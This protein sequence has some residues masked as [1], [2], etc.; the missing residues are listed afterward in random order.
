VI[1]KD[2]LARLD[3]IAQAMI[4]SRPDLDPLSLHEWVEQH[5][6]KLTKA[7]REAAYAILGLYPGFNNS[8]LI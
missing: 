4:E 6:N 8:E 5:H 2:R 7:E 1:D 3:A